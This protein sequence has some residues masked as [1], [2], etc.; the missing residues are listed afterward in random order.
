[1][2]PRLELVEAA[3]RLPTR[4]VEPASHR[5]AVLAGTMS[6]QPESD[7]EYHTPDYGRSK[8]RSAQVADGWV[9]G[10]CGAKSDDSSDRQHL[11][12][13]LRR[14]AVPHPTEHGDGETCQGTTES[15]AVMSDQRH[16]MRVHGK[17]RF[18]CHAHELQVLWH[19]NGCHPHCH[20]RQTG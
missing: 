17:D 19:K 9:D 16:E 10:N 1:M 5:L 2:Q 3:R 4:F 20:D 18:A 11:P 7:C 13:S 12:K 14:A 6:C 8:V 15:G